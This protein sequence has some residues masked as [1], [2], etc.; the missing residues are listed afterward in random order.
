M[1]II[2]FTQ[3]FTSGVTSTLSVYVTSAFAA[4]SLTATTSI[5]SSLLAGLIKLPY[6][7]FLDIFGRPLGFFCAF[8]CM[9]MG[10]VMMAG[11]SF[12]RNT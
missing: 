3:A 7:K 8:T 9:T 1:W 2:N 4:H 5:V 10:L 6:A 12:S 11:K